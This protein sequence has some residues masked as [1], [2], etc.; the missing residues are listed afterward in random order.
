MSGSFARTFKR[1]IKG[2]GMNKLDL[3]YPAEKLA[4]ARR[5]LMAPHPH[6]ESGSFASAFHECH[7]CMSQLDL[8]EDEQACVW[9]DTIRKTIDTSGL[10]EDPK[11]IGLW[12]VKAEQLTVEEKSAFSDA[13]D[14]LA[15]WV[16]DEFRR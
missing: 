5:I 11:D 16:H 10:E 9:I 14:E 13:L 12:G 7:I 15:H 8:I 1:K 3:T 2:V 4:G 6:G